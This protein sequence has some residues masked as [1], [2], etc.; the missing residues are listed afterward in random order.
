MNRRKPNLK[1][2]VTEDAIQTPAYVF[3]I[4]STW[5]CMNSRFVFD[6]SFAELRATWTNAQPLQLM[7]RHSLW[8]LMIWRKSVI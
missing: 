7:I 3:K 2:Q 5:V 8:K 6:S 4:Y 1:I